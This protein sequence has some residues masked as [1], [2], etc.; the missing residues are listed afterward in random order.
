MTTSRSKTVCRMWRRARISAARPSG[1]MVMDRIAAIAGSAAY[2]GDSP[3]ACAIAAAYGRPA[4]WTGA[5]EE[6]PSFAVAV[7]CFGRH[8][9]GG[10]PRTHTPA[11]GRQDRRAGRRAGRSTRC[12]RGRARGYS[13]YLG[14]ERA[15]RIRLP[16]G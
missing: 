16:C 2:I 5:P 14:A 11:R 7:G 8:R 13:N 12:P 6:A 10:D 1:Q 3:T 4:V 9:R 15:L